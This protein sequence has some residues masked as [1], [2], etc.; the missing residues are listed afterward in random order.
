M[1]AE[2]CLGSFDDFLVDFFE[3]YKTSVITFE[4]ITS[5]NNSLSHH[6]EKNSSH[7]TTHKSVYANYLES[8]CVGSCENMCVY[9]GR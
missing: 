1:N 8:L 4:K 9:E 3:L 5:N 2:L 6:S 7:Q